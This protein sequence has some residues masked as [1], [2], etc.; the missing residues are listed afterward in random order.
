M[1]QKKNSYDLLAD[2]MLWFGL[3]ISLFFWVFTSFLRFFNS[4][5]LSLSSVFLGTEFE[6]YNLLIVICLFIVYGSHAQV[7]IR[8][9]KIAEDTLRESEEKYRTILES[10]EEGYYEIDLDGQ[11]IF[12]NTS[13]MKI[14]DDSRDGL[15]LTKLADHLEPQSKNRFV[16]LLQAFR[17]GR[18][19][20]TIFEG[21]LRT[22]GGG[23]K[24][25]EMSISL[26]T[27]AQRESSGFRGIIRDITE[28]RMLEKSLLQSLNNVK[29]ARAGIILGLAKLAEHRD[30][31]TGRHLERMREFSRVL[32]VQ[33][34]QHPKYCDYISEDY[35][36][37][38]Y[39][40]SILHDIG[41]VG[42]PDA[43]LLKKGRLTPEEFE[44]IK[45]HSLLGGKTLSAVD[46]QFKNQSF[47]TIAKEIAYY[48]HERWD[49]GGYPKGL[50]GEAIPLSA[51][52]VTV[53]DVYDALTSKRCYKDAFSHEE[54]RAIILEERGRMFDPDIVDAFVSTEQEF[55]RI[56]REM[57]GLGEGDS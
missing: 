8:K 48:H 28:K 29:E 26:I 3:G 24:V 15:L 31:D 33:L 7:N 27:N 46:A 43:I 19:T 25:V 11:F 20:A 9:R 51:R 16:P 5:N 14:M 45:T 44:V 38:I 49:G 54:A 41:K 21:E 53:S 57:G 4:P 50:S 12:F 52:I 18:E 55:L 22:K 13:T 6:L 34:A 23:E 10:I 36:E 42:V 1:I 56:R 40:S 35:I 2:S 39:H 30:T 17:Q 32:V 47:L 37:D